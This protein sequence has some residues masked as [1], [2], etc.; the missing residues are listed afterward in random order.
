MWQSELAE[1]TIALG[2]KLLPSVQNAWHGLS[3]L[4]EEGAELPAVFKSKAIQGLPEIS[5]EGAGADVSGLEA[6]AKTVDT[7]VS[8]SANLTLR[9]IN[10]GIDWKPKGLW[11]SDKL[12]WVPR[13]GPISPTDVVRGFA[14]H[15]DTSGARIFNVASRDNLQSL[16]QRYGKLSEFPSRTEAKISLSDIDLGKLHGASEPELRAF[17]NSDINWSEMAKNF[18]GI[19]VSDYQRIRGAGPIPSWFDG[20]DMNSS[21][22][23]N[24]VGKVKITPLGKVP[25]FYDPAFQEKLN[26]LVARAGEIQGIPSAGR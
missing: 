24:N 16:I 17:R 8:A 9:D 25:S 5:I 7:H 26:A 20:L 15:V 2:K 3:G 4:M 11:A 18:D 1:A 19:K 21:V 6:A 23:W 10:P 22:T 13:E 12:A 14:Y